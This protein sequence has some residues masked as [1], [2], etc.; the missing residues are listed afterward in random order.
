MAEAVVVV[1]E[2][3]G[4]ILRLQSDADDEYKEYSIYALMIRSF[5]MLLLRMEGSFQTETDISS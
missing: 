3:Q 1:I 4:V 5:Q 2:V